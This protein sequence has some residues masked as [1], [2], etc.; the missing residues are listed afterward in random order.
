MLIYLNNEMYL[1]IVSISYL[2]VFTVS[3]GPATFAF[4]GETLTDI[5][6]GIAMSQILNS[7]AIFYIMTLQMISSLPDS[8]KELIIYIVFTIYGIMAFGFA[9]GKIK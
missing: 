5:S 4:C 1:F 3:S 6:L 2:V 9:K 8:N 7:L